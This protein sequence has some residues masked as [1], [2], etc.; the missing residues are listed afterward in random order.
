MAKPIPRRYVCWSDLNNYFKKADLLKG[1]TDLEKTELRRN[2]GIMEYTGEGGQS[3]P[4]EITY[5]SLHDLVRRGA[6]VVGARYII[7][8]F[9][10]IYSSNVL[11]SD[12]K[13]ISWGDLINPS[14]VYNLVVI[15]NTNSTLDPRAVILEHLDWV[16]EYD[17]TQI[18]LQDGVK[19]R[20]KITYLKDENGNSAYY[21][22]KNV[23][24][25][26]TKEELLGTNLNLGTEKEFLD[27]YTFS[28]LDNWEV[29]EVSTLDTT[30]YNEI[31]EDCWNNVFIGD[32]YNNLI[33]SGCV[34]NTFLRG[35]H[36]TT[37]KWNSVNNL[38]NENVC[39]TSGSIYNKT[40]PVGDT[41]FSMSITKTIQKVYD[42]TLVSYLD[43]TTYAYQ[44]ILL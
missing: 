40:I 33:E 43:P 31:K 21:D 38:F 12:R 13:Y 7:T 35:C 34:N 11:G 32:T 18:T 5:A 29:I 8:D 6:L 20:G 42:R 25:R 15:A 44:I 10:T 28:D 17:I 36:D 39:Y 30:K 1:L 41:T 26:R 24:F 22:F 9:K 2:I 14:S 19:N 37:I 27:L 16:V 3:R 23:K 4:V